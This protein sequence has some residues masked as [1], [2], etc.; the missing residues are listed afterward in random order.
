MKKLSLLAL[1]AF[2]CAHLQAQSLFEGEYILFGLG[3]Q[4]ENFK[5]DL[6]SPLQYR[7]YSGAAALG[8]HSQLSQLK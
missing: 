1:L 7:G 6:V 3:G 4:M 5:D 8:W 2:F